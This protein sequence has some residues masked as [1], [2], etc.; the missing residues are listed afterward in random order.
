MLRI[1]VLFIVCFGLTGCASPVNCY[2]ISS[3]DTWVSGGPNGYN[4]RSADY[5]GSKTDET[6]GR[7]WSVDVGLNLHWDPSCERESYEEAGDAP[8][9]SPVP[10]SRGGGPL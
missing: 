9:V 5:R 1:A 2:R 4:S 7:G 3:A 10:N 6:R 8:T